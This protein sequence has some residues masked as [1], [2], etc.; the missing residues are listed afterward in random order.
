[1]IIGFRYIYNMITCIPIYHKYKDRTMIGLREYIE[2][3]SLIDTFVPGDVLKNG[4]IVE[5]GT[6]RGGMAA[7]LIEFCGKDKSYYFFDSFEG[8]PE[9]KEI[10]GKAALEW[11]ANKESPL[12]HDNCNAPLELFKNT[13]D[14]TGVSYDNVRII[15]GF[16]DKSFQT[17]EPPDISVLRL[18]ADWYESTMLC[19]E[20][21]WDFVIHSGIIL[22]DDYYSWD[23]CSRAVH[24][25]LSKRKAVEQIKMGPVADVAFILKK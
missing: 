10:D 3:L 23:G 17:F 7:G 1:M 9:A 22:I 16:Y 19:M 11:Q 6:W 14:R 13:I 24:D 21:F 5:C 8:L 18:D 15:K 12:Y 20:K 4:A 25:F 2:N